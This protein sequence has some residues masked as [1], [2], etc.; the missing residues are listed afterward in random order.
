MKGNWQEWQGHLSDGPRVDP[1]GIEDGQ[2]ALF[3]QGITEHDQQVSLLVM[4]GPWNK[5][6][7]PNKHLVGGR[8]DLGGPVLRAQVQ[9]QHAVK[10]VPVLGV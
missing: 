1:T 8:P 10:G 9:S 7:L 6:G 5:D 3:G 2:A 4:L